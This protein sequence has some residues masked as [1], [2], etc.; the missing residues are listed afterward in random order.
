MPPDGAIGGGQRAAPNLIERLIARE[1]AIIAACLV[2]SVALAW[3]WLMSK[4]RGPDMDMGGA[5]MSLSYLSS[6][7]AMWMVMMVGMMLPSAAPMILFYGRFARQ[8]GSG[9]LGRTALFAS[10]YLFVWLLFSAVAALGQAALVTGGHVDR[11]GLFLGSRTLSA[12][13]LVLAS[14]YQLMPAKR[15]CLEQCQ[16][17]LSFLMRRWRSGTTGALRLGLIHGLYCLGCCW[18][19]MLLL[20]VGG[21]MNPAWVAG[22]AA[23]VLLEKL[24]PPTLRANVA[25]SLLLLLGAALLIAA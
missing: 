20:F 23:L 13:L 10:A 3:W 2:G 14:L 12:A 25:I 5:A 6:A 24:A 4:A 18:L 19:L 21:V 8:G 11:M 22:L 17:P 7:A 15:K 1:R 16:S 9:A